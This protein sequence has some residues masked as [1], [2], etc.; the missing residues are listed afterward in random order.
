M[1]GRVAHLTEIRRGIH[2]AGTEMFLPHAINQHA[3]SERM[4]R[5]REMLREGQPA[6][7]LGGVL[8]E[9]CQARREWMAAPAAAW[10]HHGAIAGGIGRG[11]VG[12]E[13]L[14][15]GIAPSQFAL[16]RA[17]ADV[18][19][20]RFDLVAPTGE[21]HCSRRALVVRARQSI[22]RVGDGATRHRALALR[23]RNLPEHRSR[24]AR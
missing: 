3:G 6:C 24:C 10:D 23:S 11:K 13:G 22:A 12:G 20:E 1:R 17:V 16:C 19:H 9:V 2:E 4:I 15:S 14:R 8:A 5:T 21:L 7:G 18:S